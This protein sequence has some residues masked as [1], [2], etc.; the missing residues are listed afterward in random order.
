MIKSKILIVLFFSIILNTFIIADDDY[1]D[2]EKYKNKF[3][4]SDKYNL[5]KNF[6]FLDLNS[7]QYIQLK[8]ILIEYNS[9]YRKLHDYKEELEDEIEDILEKENFDSQRFSN[10][11]KDI[12]YKEIELETIKIEKIHKILSKKQRKKL[13]KYVEEWELE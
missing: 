10:L 4:K 5:Y 8:D 9:E 3:Y 6:D 12:K 11:L 1:D 7:I 2:F 13:A